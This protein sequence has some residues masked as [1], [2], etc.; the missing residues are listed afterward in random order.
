MFIV[1]VWKSKFRNLLQRSILKSHL[2]STCLQPEPKSSKLH[3]GENIV[4]PWS[5][6]WFSQTPSCFPFPIKKPY[7]TQILGQNYFGLF[8]CSSVEKHLPTSSPRLHAW[9]Q[10]QVTNVRLPVLILCLYYLLD[11]GRKLPLVKVVK[12]LHILLSQ[13][14][15]CFSKIF[16]LY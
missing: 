12:I 7:W 13:I 2:L 11:V 6:T 10:R 14:I 5:F 8:R 4:W 16:T 3:G 15:Y 9:T 1:F